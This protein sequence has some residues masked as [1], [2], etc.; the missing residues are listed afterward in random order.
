MLLELIAYFENSAL[1]DSVRENDVLFP[2]I[3]SVHVLAICLVVGSIF[4]V[5][6]RLVG[7]ASIHRPVSRLT[8]GI[9]PLTWCAFAVAVASGSLLFISNA[10]KY[11]GNGYFVAKM[12]LICAAGLN[13]AL[14]HVISGRDQARWDNDIRPPLP[15][16]LAGGLSIVLWIAVV[17][18]GRWIGFTMKVG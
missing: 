3:E 1:A 8:H 18:C 7:L 12:V 14:F 11:L 16:R 2:L 17:A 13:M 5:D 6:L 9:L 15:A 4:A 10:T